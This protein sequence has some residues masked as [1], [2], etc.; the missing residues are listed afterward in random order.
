MAGM[1]AIS[2]GIA[3]ARGA[4]RLCTRSVGHQTNGVKDCLDLSAASHR[5]QLSLQPSKHC[6]SRPKQGKQAL[7]S[8][9]SH[10]PWPV[11]QGRVS[12]LS[13]S[14]TN[15]VP[16]LFGASA[17]V[18]ACRAES[19]AVDCLPIL[20]NPWESFSQHCSHTQPSHQSHP[21]SSVPA[22]PLLQISIPQ[23]R[24]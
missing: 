11:G 12:G 22:A 14:S 15:T 7:I 23:F 8:S 2:P 18:P 17:C 13:S 19:P 4:T 3:S 10:F 6:V 9:G 16:L 24:H 20:K 21:I 5:S 1:G